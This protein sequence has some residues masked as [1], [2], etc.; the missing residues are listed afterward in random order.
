MTQM[1]LVASETYALYRAGRDIR[2]GCVSCRR[3]ARSFTNTAA[4][5]RCMHAS[6]RCF[7]NAH[8]SAPPQSNAIALG[9]QN[10]TLSYDTNI[11]RQVGLAGSS[12]IVTAC[13]KCLMDFFD[14]T[15]SD[16]PKHLQ[17][18]F[19]L[20]VEMDELGI[21]AGLQVRAWPREKSCT[22]HVVGL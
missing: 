15:E 8:N 6:T 11:P 19:V 16:I 4:Y 5:D 7:P 17:P 1:S 10:F 9:R 3:P 20:S 14:I 18:S 12:A 2:E 22:A 13:F 21:A